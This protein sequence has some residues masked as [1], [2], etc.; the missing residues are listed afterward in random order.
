MGQRLTKG[1]QQDED[2]QQPRDL[3]SL[4]DDLLRICLSAPPLE[5][6]RRSS[7]AALA[8]CKSLARALAH[9][10]LT[11][12]CHDVEHAGCAVRAAKLLQQLWG[13]EEGQQQGKDFTMVLFNECDASL[14]P[15]LSALRDAGVRLPFI[16]ELHLQVRDQHHGTSH[17]A[18]SA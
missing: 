12:V 10:T 11:G 4:P 16:T 13:E 3:L 17:G 5:G 7:R 15:Y 14:G 8:S 18:G 1:Q 2:Q 9:T 6:D